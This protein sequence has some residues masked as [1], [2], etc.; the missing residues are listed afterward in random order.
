[1]CLQGI[2]KSILVCLVLNPI[3]LPEGLANPLVWNSCGHALHPGASRRFSAP[4][5][6]GR[7]AHT[8]GLIWVQRGTSLSQSGYANFR[9]VPAFLSKIAHSSHLMS[10][11]LLCFLPSLSVHRSGQSQ[12]WRKFPLLCCV[13]RLV[14]AAYLSGQGAPT[15]MLLKEP[16]SLFRDEE[17]TDSTAFPVWLGHEGAYCLNFMPILGVFH[18]CWL[19]E[20]LC[21]VE[22]SF[23]WVFL[24]CGGLTPTPL[25]GWHRH[26]EIGSRWK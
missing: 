7:L 4:L 1:M 11:L 18:L 23:F 14:P 3:C 2:P 13:L 10:C 24:C 8:L 5:L 25:Y 22:M 12:T 16:P 26:I 17:M 9:E 21:L 6:R 15:E 19:W 20:C